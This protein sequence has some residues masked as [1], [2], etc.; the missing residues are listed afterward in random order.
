MTPNDFLSPD[1]P[2]S[3]L[4]HSGGPFSGLRSAAGC[5]CGILLY[6]GRDG[7]AH[8]AAQALSTP[9]G[10]FWHGIVHRREPDPGNAAYWFRRVGRHPV[11]PTLRAAVREVEAQFPGCRLGMGADWDPI[12]WID[13]WESARRDTDSSQWRMATEIE[14]VEWRV[15]FD[16]CSEPL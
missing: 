16:Y 1:A 5:V 4:T 12:V 10:A 15:L 9:D 7:E 14:R 2:L 3:L 11:F 6:H 8:E 13:F